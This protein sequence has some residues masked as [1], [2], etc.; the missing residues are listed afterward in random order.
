MEQQQPAR[1]LVADDSATV[2]ALVRLEL[3]AHGYDVVEAEDGAQALA[4]AEAGG[5]DAVLLDVE[6]PV[7]DGFATIQ[8]LKGDP[9]PGTCRSSS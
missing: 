3:E 1:I 9:R 4:L 2:R 6:M 8:R 5:V 7:L